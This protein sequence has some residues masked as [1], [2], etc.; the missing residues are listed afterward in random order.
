MKWTYKNI[1]EELKIFIKMLLTY[2]RI[3]VILITSKKGM[4]LAQ[5]LFFY[6]LNKNIKNI[7]HN[8]RI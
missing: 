8:E 1:S 3:G 2:L 4:A 5:C 6:K 7:S